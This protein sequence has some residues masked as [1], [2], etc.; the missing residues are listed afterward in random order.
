MRM[1]RARQIR[2]DLS[3]LTCRARA[4]R[5]TAGAFS[6]STS[7][8]ELQGQLDTPRIVRL[9]GGGDL[10]K[11]RLRHGCIRPGEEHVIERVQEIG[12]EFHV[13]VSENFGILL[14]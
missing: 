12:P 14:Q 4:I 9:L 6:R 5:V 7:E 1:T 11:G 3:A 8:G 13:L 10:P 2:A